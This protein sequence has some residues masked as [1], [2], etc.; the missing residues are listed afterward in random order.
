MS[1]IGAIFYSIDGSPHGKFSSSRGLRQGD[2]FSPFL[3]IL[4]AEALSQ[5]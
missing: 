4:G 5:D 1:I 3:F 2:P